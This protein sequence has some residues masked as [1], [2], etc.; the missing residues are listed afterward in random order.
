M[1]TYLDYILDGYIH[2]QVVLTVGLWETIIIIEG[3]S[4]GNTAWIQSLQQGYIY[5]QSSGWLYTVLSL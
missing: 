5:R 1:A 2:L 3:E 4:C